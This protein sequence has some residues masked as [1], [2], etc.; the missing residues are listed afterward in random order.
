[1][2]TSPNYSNNRPS[3]LID[4]MSTFSFYEANSSF[5]T[6]QYWNY[7]RTP[8][9][10]VVATELSIYLAAQNMAIIFLNWKAKVYAS[11][12]KDK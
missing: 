11:W 3:Y 9:Y 4:S 10:K 8:R 2:N 5:V 12:Q 6:E 1:M 7:H